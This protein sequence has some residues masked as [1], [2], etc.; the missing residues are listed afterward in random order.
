MMMLMIIDA[1]SLH[2][3]QQSFSLLQRNNCHG[4]NN[5]C[6]LPVQ[7]LS[8]NNKQTTKLIF[9]SSNN[10]IIINY[11]Y[12]TRWLDWSFAAILISD[13]AICTSAALR[14]STRFSPGFT[15]NKHSSPSFGSFQTS[16]NSNLSENFKIGQ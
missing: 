1:V 4:I 6:I 9:S 3:L 14:A 2:A 13:E 8:C 16:S 11:Y 5:K 7:T 15:L 12:F 10:N